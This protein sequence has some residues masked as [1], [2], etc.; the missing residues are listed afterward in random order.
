MK[1]FV[2]FTLILSAC[3]IF[4]HAQIKKDAVLLG[5]QVSVYSSKPS[6]NSA[7]PKTNNNNIFLNLSVGKAIKENTVIGLYGGYGQGKNENIYSISASNISTS[8]TTSAGIFYRKYKSLGKNFYFFGELNAGYRGYKQE[9]EN[10]VI[11]AITT[12]ADT[13][14]GVE[15][16]LTPGISYRLFKKLQL[17]VLMPSFAGLRYAT[18]KNSGSNITTTKGSLFQLSSNLNSGLLNNMALGFK[19]VL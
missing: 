16:G 17:E 19:F 7:S 4:T 9:Y 10:R 15:L 6:G 12:S 3:C 18:T 5:G 8:T 1:K 2:A 14:N 11:G 13:E